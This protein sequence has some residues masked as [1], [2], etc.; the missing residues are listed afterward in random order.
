MLPPQRV[1]ML[2]VLRRLVPE[3]RLWH[4]VFTH[5]IVSLSAS[6]PIIFWF[7]FFML[8]H[9]GFSWARR[10]RF[11]KPLKPDKKLFSCVDIDECAINSGGCHAGATCSNTEG[12][13]T[14]TCP[15]G[16]EGDGFTCSGVFSG[17]FRGN[18]V[19][20]PPFGPTMKIFYRRL[21]MKRCVFCRFPANFRK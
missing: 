15:A 17:V 4:H 14:C 2:C 9:S 21:Y 8:F 16:Y 19:R 10:L 13:F 7:Y 20:C 1:L 3:N 5:V 6:K 12:A 18:M 11:T